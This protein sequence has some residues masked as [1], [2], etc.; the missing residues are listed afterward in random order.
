VNSANIKLGGI[1]GLALCVN[2][3]SVETCIERY[4]HLAKVAFQPRPSPNIPV[5]SQIIEF[6]ISFIA[7]GRYS[8]ENLEK[9]LQETFGSYRSILDCSKATATGTRIGV[10]VTTI[11]D[12][13]TCIFT[14][15]NGIGSRPAD[16]GKLTRKLCC[17][18]LSLGRV[19][20]SPAKRRP[21]RNT[22]MGNASSPN[23]C[24]E[25]S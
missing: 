20:H 15:Y 8:A 13:S 9:A 16:C 21:N 14:N 6:L 4:E 5:L 1:I 18:Y 7:D 25:Q 24:I 19:S 22:V 10:P 3:W 11:D 23:F 12:A 17:Q 2:G